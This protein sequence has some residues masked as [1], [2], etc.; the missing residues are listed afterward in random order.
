M[1]MNVD[2]LSA[3]PT[4]LLTKLYKPRVADTWIERPRL[5]QALDDGLTRKL[6]LVDAPA[7]YGKTTL[8]AQWLSAQR[9]PSAWLSLDEADDDLGV[10]LAYVAQAVHAVYPHS[11]QTT[12]MLLSGARLPPLDDLTTVIINEFDALPDDLILVL[13]D[14]H[15]V[16]SQQITQLLSRVVMHPPSNLHLALATRSDPAL[17]LAR[18]RARGELIEIRAS[19]LRFLPEEARTFIGGAVRQPLS[20]STMRILEEQ[21]EGWPAGLRLAALSLTAAGDRQT[22]ITAF[23]SQGSLHITDYLADEV[24]ARLAGAM[25]DFLLRAALPERFC[26]P[27]CDALRDCIPSSND[28]D[29]APDSNVL[30]DEIKRQ[31]LFLIPLDNSGE[32]FRFHPLFR[33]V[34]RNKLRARVSDEDMACLHGRASDWLAAHGWLEE[35][36][37]RAQAAADMSRVIRLIEANMHDV[38]NREEA[39]TLQRWLALVPEEIV[40]RR[41]RLLLAHAYLKVMRQESA[42]VSLVVNQAERLLNEESPDL[43]TDERA[44]AMGDALAVR[45]RAMLDAAMGPACA[46]LAEE[47]LRLLP[48]RHYYA[49]ATAL[50]ARAAGLQMAGR[51]AEADAFLQQEAARPGAMSTYTL[52]ILQ[53]QWIVAA[54]SGDTAQSGAIAERYVAAEATGLMIDIGWAHT[55]AG[56][57][58]QEINELDR[59]IEH[60]EVVAMHRQRAGYRCHFVAQTQLALAYHAT[61]RPDLADGAL[62]ALRTYARMSGSPIA[63]MRIDVTA[64]RLR[65]LRG[66]LA[67]AICWVQSASAQSHPAELVFNDIPSLTRAQILIAQRSSEA[68][69]EATVHL[70]NLRSRAEAW[71]YHYQLAKI[72]AVQA[73]LLWAS[74]RRDEALGVMADAATIGQRGGL[75]R[76]FADLG[77]DVCQVM[78]M[79]A[80]RASRYGLQNAY[81]SVVLDA[82][83]NVPPS[84]AAHVARPNLTLTQRETDVLELLSKRRTDKEIADVLVIS[85]LTVSRHTANIYRKLGVASRREAVK[86]AQTLGILDPST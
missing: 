21:T 38:L 60:F 30:L 12:T 39:L 14:F 15:L 65:L 3:G 86:K 35:A 18:L 49:R 40:Q 28:S 78:H 81:L 36:L 31:N 69:A 58:R 54:Y 23:A 48:E 50:A 1:E 4:L 47:A 7:G 85:R 57:W 76:A 70:H 61:G 22:F 63:W 71:H 51:K 16:Q 73:S 43:T 34:L 44:A 68:L 19:D 27:L 79:L 56:L 33:N 13:D 8:L 72:L 5:L 24:L 74:N 84:D 67:G 46:Q 41:P 53:Y 2:V 59:A 25:K 20:E 10:F 32:W 26:A 77:A 82:F 9:L 37:Q 55:M 45:A 64:A 17:P 42:S 66:D 29:D 83:G 11:M 52:R 75:I 80:E 62:D 6:I